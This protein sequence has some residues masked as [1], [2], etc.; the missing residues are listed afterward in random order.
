MQSIGCVYTSRGMASSESGLCCGINP[1]R[2]ERSKATN[3]ESDVILWKRQ[4]S[5][6]KEREKVSWNVPTAILPCIENHHLVRYVDPTDAQLLYG[7]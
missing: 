4:P 7:R 5:R 2:L 1:S 3:T 6:L